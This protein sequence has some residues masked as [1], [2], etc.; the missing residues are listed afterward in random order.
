MKLRPGNAFLALCV[1][2]LCL[3]SCAKFRDSPVKSIS[4]AELTKFRVTWD[5]EPSFK[6][7]A[8]LGHSTP[9]RIKNTGQSSLPIPEKWGDRYYFPEGSIQVDLHGSSGLNAARLVANEMRKVA[10]GIE[11]ESRI[12]IIQPT[13]FGYYVYVDWGGDEEHYT[14]H[15]VEMVI[16]LDRKIIW[17]WKC[18]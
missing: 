11:P 17:W 16:D 15:V 3:L 9:E 4:K 8:T 2:L 12:T 5:R 7:K 10:C 13:R 14:G 6:A 1:V 18:D